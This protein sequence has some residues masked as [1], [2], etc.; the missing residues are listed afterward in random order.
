[1][2]SL[3][4]SGKLWIETELGLKNNTVSRKNNNSQLSWTATCSLSGFQVPSCGRGLK[5]EVFLWSSWTAPWISVRSSVVSL[6]RR[7]GARMHGVGSPSSK[8]TCLLSSL[9]LSVRVFAWHLWLSVG[10]S[11]PVGSRMARGTRLSS[12]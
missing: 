5:F 2:K 12:I 7:R 8:W 10:S 9:V 4:S 1:M 3:D 11:C 6:C